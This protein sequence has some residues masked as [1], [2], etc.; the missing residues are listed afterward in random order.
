M[1]FF[2]SQ[3]H[4]L[5]KWLIEKLSKLDEKHSFH[6]IDSDCGRIGPPRTV[7]DANAEPN[8]CNL[9]KDKLTIQSQ[10]PFLTV[11]ANCCIFKG[12]WMYE[13]NKIIIFVSV[14]IALCADMWCCRFNFDL[15]VLCKLDGVHQNVNSL[16]TLVLVIHSTVMD[17]MEVNKGYGMLIQESTQFFC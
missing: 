6:F 5:N 9:S 4:E 2:F 10:S 11:K 8:N 3:I 13:V 12:K 15:K 7:I 1:S 17:W 16:K 14:Y